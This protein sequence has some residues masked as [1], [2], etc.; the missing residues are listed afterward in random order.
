MKAVRLRHAQPAAHVDHEALALGDDRIGSAP[1]ILG[2][3]QTGGERG[4]EPR[5]NALHPARV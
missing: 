1:A 3:T 2:A 4:R 5:R